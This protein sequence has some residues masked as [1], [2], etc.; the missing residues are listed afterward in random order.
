MVD[1][2]CW[3]DRAIISQRYLEQNQQSMSLSSYKYY[4]Q[5]KEKYLYVKVTISA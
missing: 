4:T 1:N 2:N 3:F 5:Y